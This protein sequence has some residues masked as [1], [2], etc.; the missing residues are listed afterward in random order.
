MRQ[1]GFEPRSQRW[2]RRILV[3]PLKLSN[4]YPTAAKNNEWAHPDFRTDFKF[5]QLFEPGILT[6][7]TFLHKQKSCKGDVITTRPWA[8]KEFYFYIIFKCYV[9]ILTK[10]LNH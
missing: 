2:Q 9:K 1:R 3:K 5:N 4:H 10:H 7:L 8:L 6:S